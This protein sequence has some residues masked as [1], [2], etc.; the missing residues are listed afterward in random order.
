MVKTKLDEVALA[1]QNLLS[2]KENMYWNSIGVAATPKRKSLRQ[3]RVNNQ[4]LSL[5]MTWRKWKSQL[6]G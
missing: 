4:R 6:H 1:T 2:D 5:W 3:Q